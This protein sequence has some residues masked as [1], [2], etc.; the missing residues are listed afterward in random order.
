MKGYRR[1]SLLAASVAM[2]WALGSAASAQ[3]PD[4]IA[5][6]GRPLSRPSMR[7]GRRSTSA[8]PMR[9]ASA[10]GI[11]SRSRRSLLDG[12]TVGRHYA[13]PKL[14]ARRRQRGDGRVAARAPGASP[15]DIPWLKLDVDAAPRHRAAI[16]CDDRPAH[17]DEGRHRGGCCERAGAYLSVPYAA[18]DVFLRK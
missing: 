12:K 3:V 16:G 8:R 15:K 2:L 7:R 10:P 1:L 14:G 11:R 18:E 17:Q 5:A 13:G 4:A 6:P 9:A